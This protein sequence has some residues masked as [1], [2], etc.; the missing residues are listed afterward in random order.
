M[1]KRVQ[2]FGHECQIDLWFT[3]E[4]G[5]VVSRVQSVNDEISRRSSAIS[6]PKLSRQFVL[7]DCQRTSSKKQRDCCLIH[8]R[9]PTAGSEASPWKPYGQP[10]TNWAVNRRPP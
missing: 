8:S 7:I 4:S 3:I 10:H 9:A 2:G 1:A 5:Q 6:W